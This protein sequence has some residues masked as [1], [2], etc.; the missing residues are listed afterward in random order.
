MAR[1]QVAIVGAGN[2][3]RVHVEQLYTLRDRTYRGTDDEHAT[4]QRYESHAG[5]VPDWVSNVSDLDPAVT[6]LFDPSADQRERTAALCAEHGDDPATFDDFEAFLAEATYNAVVL[7][8]P[9]DYHAAQADA[10]LRRD[11]DVLCE[12]PLADDL[13]GHDRIAAAA[14]D[15]AGTL[16]PAYNLRS[17]PFFARLKDLVDDGAVGDLGMVTCQEVRAPFKDSYHYYQDRSGGALLDKNCHDFDLF[18][19]YVGADPVRVSATGGQHVLDRDATALDQAS[20][21][22][23]YADGTVGTLELCMYAPWGQRGRSYELRGDAGLL[24]SPEE[25]DTI[26]RYTRDG[27]ERIGVEATGSHGGADIIQM[28]RFLRTLDGAAEPPGDLDDAKKAAAVAIAAERAVQTGE[29]VRIDDGYDLV[30]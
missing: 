4:E 6:A 17:A 7:A 19:W 22:V 29:S 26:D 11:V 30:E 1:P 14:R 21:V 15:S 13:A 28:E 12:K 5:D 20:V 24:R 18:N 3:A 9:N 10:L 8:S 25:S 23:E 27:R 2:R 16:Y